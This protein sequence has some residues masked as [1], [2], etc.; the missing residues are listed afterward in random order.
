MQ[1]KSPS[2][3][4][5]IDR[6]VAVLK[7]SL[8]STW[9]IAR[10]Q[11][12]RA[13]PSRADAI[14]Q[15]G[16]SNQGM[17]RIVVEART[18]FTPKDVETVVGRARLLSRVGGEVPFLVVAPWLS[19]RS[20]VLLAEAGLNYLDLAGNVRLT[21][22]YP[23]LFVFRESKTKGP[24]RPESRLSLR[25][26]KAG[27][28]VRLLLDVAP[29]YG[30][31]ELARYASV[32]PGY[33]S[34]LLDMLD[35]EAILERSSRGGVAAVDWRELLKRRAENYGV[36]TSNATERYVCPSGP[37]YAL[38]RIGDSPPSNIALTGSFPVER[39]ISVAPP[40]LLILYIRSSPKDLVDLAGLLPADEGANVVLATPS[41]PVVM[42][43][44]WPAASPE[45]SRVAVVAASQLALDC[46]T[47]NGRMPLEGAAFLDWMGQNEEKWR[48]RRLADLPQLGAGT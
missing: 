9:T 47:G 21:S 4:E 13:E 35:R 41:D 8:P 15:V 26:T 19:E 43:S 29:P 10:I 31:L 2:E 3:S 14:L 33:V 7:E 42:E 25:G 48:F 17:A 16:S 28:I 22:T 45:S 32:T 12:D 27:R 23:A 30:V 39:V 1:S 46:L 24:S 34:R 37:G 40:A 11:D 5:L 18:S 44:R 20:R 38:E 6:A 36:F